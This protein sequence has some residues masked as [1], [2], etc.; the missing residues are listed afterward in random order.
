MVDAFAAQMRFLV[1]VLPFVAEDA[2][3]ALKG[4][5]AVSLTDRNWPCLSVD[6]E[7]IHL[8]A[9]HARRPRR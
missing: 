9:P 6:I 7:P 2:S 3:F 8:S 1:Q 4:G 5:R